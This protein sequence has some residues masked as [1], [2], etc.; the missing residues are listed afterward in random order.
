MEI[1]D[2]PS[3]NDFINYLP[4]CM[5]TFNII[6]IN[7]RSLIKNFSLVLQ[8]IN[9]SK[10]DID[11]IILTEVGISRC[12]DLTQLFCIGGYKMCSEL[13]EHRKGGGI[14]IYVKDCHNF[15]TLDNIKLKHCESLFIKIKIFNHYTTHICAIYRPPKESKHLFITALKRSLC[16]DIFKHTDLFLL[17]DINIDLKSPN[18]IC[19]YY[20]SSLAECGLMNAISDFTRIEK[21]AETITKSSIDHIFARSRSLDLYSAVLST[22]MADHR[23]CVLSCVG[24]GANGDIQVTGLKR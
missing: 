20:K 7:I 21:R 3:I 19:D 24:I 9:Q 10:L 17:G 12:N 14:I 13:R 8:L 11:V 1:H 18:N 2:C 22:V 5:S 23:M 4:K 15:I 16:S 6:H